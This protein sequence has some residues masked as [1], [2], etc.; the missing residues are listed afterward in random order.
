[1][2]QLVPE[3]RLK[4]QRKVVSSLPMLVS[5]RV[6]R[7][8]CYNLCRFLFCG[9]CWWLRRACS[10]LGVTNNTTKVSIHIYILGSIPSINFGAHLP[11]CFDSKMNEADRYF[12]VV[13]FRWKSG[14]INQGFRCTKKSRLLSLPRKSCQAIPSNEQWPKSTITWGFWWGMK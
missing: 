3:N 14:R 7:V 11:I 12:F 4:P 10:R 6:C 1:M 2:K 8:V 5:G 13:R 9:L